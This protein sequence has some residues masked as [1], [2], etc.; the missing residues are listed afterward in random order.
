MKKRYFIVPLAVLI[1]IWLA[2]WIYGY[3]T[4]GRIIITS[5]NPANAISLVSINDSS[6][7]LSSRHNLTAKL[8]D[9]QYRAI[10][11]GTAGE[12]HQQI[13]ITGR[14]TFRFTI[15]PASVLTTAEPVVGE[16]ARNL[17]A[18]DDLSYIETSGSNLHQIDSQNNINQLGSGQF[19]SVRWINALS[20]VGLDYQGHL[21]SIDN[22]AVK[23][24]K[25]PTAYANYYAVSP[26]GTIYIAYGKAV[27]RSAPGGV[28]TKFY[29]AK[30]VFTSLSAF[31]GGVAVINSL[32]GDSTSSNK[33]FVVILRDS[34]STIQK[35]IQVSESAVWSPDG[36]YLATTNTSG[37][38]VY[39]GSL[40]MVTNIPTSG[41]SN[42]VWLD[43]S[44]VLYVV[45]NQVWS[46]NLATLRSDKVAQV[47]LVNAINEIAV[48]GDKAY[49]YLS[50]VDS[51]NNSSVKRLGLRGQNV[52]DYIYQL[53]DFLPETLDSFSLSLVNFTSPTVNIQEN[54]GTNPQGDLA[55]AS[56]ELTSN[57]FD[58]SKITLKLLPPILNE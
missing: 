26:D 2:I 4:T 34:G 41:A 23:Q 48:S 35:G 20:G 22:G 51:A 46:F 38:V 6:F 11:A 53:Q 49:L 45:D 12:A 56:N 21:Y 16:G 31:N 27:Y 24:I 1:C 14:K 33:P 42:I 52:P 29:T 37:C 58:V 50:I 7:S 43:K 10:V 44:R 9:G 19:Q 13:N 28:F 17:V 47:P 30:N 3:L 39:D 36:K 5:D 57:G 15:N 32:V 54:P 18:G 8:K 40:K 25:L 55:A